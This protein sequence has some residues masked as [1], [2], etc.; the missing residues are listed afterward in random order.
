M[1]PFDEKSA[2]QR[3]S[4][5]PAVFNT[6]VIPESKINPVATKGSYIGENKPTME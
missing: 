2:M 5:R 6:G 3:N 4:L 1:V